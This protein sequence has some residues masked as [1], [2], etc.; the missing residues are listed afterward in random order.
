METDEFVWKE[1]Y[2]VGVQL[3]DEQHKLF[4]HI[5]NRVFDFLNEDLRN[6][7]KK[8]LLIGILKDLE[9]YVIYHLNSEEEYFNQFHYEEAGAHIAV[10][11]QFREKVR[12][13]MS[14]AEQRDADIKKIGKE[15]ADYAGNWLVNHIKVMDKGYGKFFH[16]H[17]VK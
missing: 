5:A 16:E 3:F 8:E 12:K 13:L 6:S 9:S 17:G 15:I 11:N 2:S 10:H 14:A 1:E 7:K 4:F